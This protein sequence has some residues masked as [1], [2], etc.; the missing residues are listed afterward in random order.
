MFGV[1]MNSL[2]IFLC[3]TLV[4]VQLFR[5]FK[6]QITGCEL[7]KT[8]VGC[9]C[10]LFPW[11]NRSEKEGSSERWFARS[12]QNR[13]QL[14]PQ[15]PHN[16]ELICR[17]GQDP[18][19]HN[20]VSCLLPFLTALSQEVAPEEDICTKYFLRHRKELLERSLPA[21]KLGSLATT[22]FAQKI[23]ILAWTQYLSK[24]VLADQLTSQWF[25]AW[26]EW[27]VPVSVPDHVAVPLVVTHTYI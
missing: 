15:V 17:D 21:W 11:G 5:S 25:R 1:E 2:E 16:T 24:S 9:S 4:P 14:W 3:K 6:P 26:T 20:E 7:S 13:D 12:L 27:A 8:W 10:R 18:R 22:Q 19:V 23:S